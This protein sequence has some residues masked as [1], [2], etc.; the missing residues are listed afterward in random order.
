[1]KK[2]KKRVLVAGIATGLFLLTLFLPG[3]P[4]SARYRHILKKVKT[5]AEMRVSAWQGVQPK[6]VSISGKILT[7]RQDGAAL[8]G[9]E[10]EALDSVSGWATLTDEEGIFFLPDVTWYPQARYTLVVTTNEYQAK[11]LSVL[12]P[13]TY[14]AGGIINIGD[15]ELAHGCATDLSNTQGRNSISLLAYDAANTDY[16]KNIFNK[17]I[18]GTET[19][20]EK[21]EAIHRYIRGKI[22]TETTTERFGSP[23]SILENGSYYSG[24]LALAFATLAKAGNYKTRLIDLIDTASPAYARMVTEV[25]YGDRWHLYDP[26]SGTALRN[27]DGMIVSYKELRLATNLSPSDALSEQRHRSASVDARGV[28]SIYQS[29]VHHYYYF[30]GE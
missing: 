28:S 21:L 7:S 17:L 12:T 14:P 11:Q 16:Y 2:A 20:E 19:D 18:E 23:R 5:K 22:I 26:T 10:V 9:A 6:L 4:W 27:Q 15:L 8:K 1:M 29:G 30:A 13:A 3:L 24:E 25:Y